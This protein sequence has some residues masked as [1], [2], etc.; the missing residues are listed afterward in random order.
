MTSSPS[1]EEPENVVRACLAP[2]QMTTSGT[3][4]NPSPRQNG[5]MASFNSGIPLAGVY[6]VNPIE[7]PR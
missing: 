4:F 2:T 5:D 7:W 3:Y 6:L 1:S